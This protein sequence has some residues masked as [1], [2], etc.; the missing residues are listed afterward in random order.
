MEVTV[1]E[2]TSPI[3]VMVN[4]QASIDQALELM[5]ENRIRHL[6]VED[7]GKVVG[8]ISERDLLTHQGKNWTTMLK[9]ADIMNPNLFSV[10]GT[11]GLGEVA[12]QLSSQKVGSALVL[13]ESGEVYGIFTTTDALNALVEIFYPEANRKSGIQNFSLE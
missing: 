5:Q 2:Y 13:D 6:P 4:A 11:E 3:L 12:F 1:D 7:L 9:V 10:Y 8:I